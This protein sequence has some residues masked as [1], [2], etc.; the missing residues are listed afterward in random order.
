MYAWRFLLA[1]II[2][3]VQGDLT[4][5]IPS[6]QGV[7]TILYT[8]FP[9]SLDKFHIV[10]NHMKWDKTSSHSTKLLYK[11]GQDFLEI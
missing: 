1:N 2:E 3:D 5:F 6:V 10:T 8:V 4:R 11:L 9:R 7:L